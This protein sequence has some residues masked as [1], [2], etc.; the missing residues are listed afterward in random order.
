MRGVA[1][2]GL[3]P[4]GGPWLEKWLRVAVALAVACVLAGLAP[5][6]AAA[7]GLSC[8]G[9]SVT[10]Q[11][12]QSVPV[13]FS[14]TGAPIS[15]YSIVSGPSNGTLGTIDQS[16]GTVTY[17]PSSGYIGSDSFT[18]EAFSS[19]TG[20]SSQ[21][22][23]NITIHPP[24]PVCSNVS[25][26][27]VEN[28]SV[29]VSLSCTNSPVAETIAVPAHGTI[30]GSFPSVIYTPD[31]GYTGA[32]SFT[33][34][35]QNSGGVSNTA[36]ITI[37]I[38]KPPAPVCTNASVSTHANQSVSV[39]LSCTNSPTSY[40]ILAPAPAHGNVGLTGTPPSE[41]ATYTPNGDYLGS[42]SFSYR[43]CNLG[44]CSM[45]TVTIT[46]NGPPPPPNLV[47]KP[48][49][50]AIVTSLR[51]PSRP[52]TFGHVATF[53]VFLMRSSLIWSSRQA[54]SVQLTITR[55]PSSATGASMAS[56][57]ASR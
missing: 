6:P 23:V 50:E 43:A 29:S 35:A 20:M 30:G 12:N 56:S 24:P 55:P 26:S 31:P 14:C 22:T 3:T 7:A 51:G 33:Y 47:I 46:I 19:Q 28:Q 11:E 8:S 32:D 2:I 41:T 16:A 4:R 42:D 25:A 40:V 49:L 13:S 9:V 53:K 18:Y 34:S 52:I 10:T 39:N 45:A 36:T 27:T 38:T 57:D 1:R 48:A 5:A 15:S 54:A 21:A 37:T 17:T 44:G